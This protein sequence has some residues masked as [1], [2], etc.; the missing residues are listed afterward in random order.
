[1]QK[2]N[3]CLKYFCLVFPFLVFKAVK[4]TKWLESRSYCTKFLCQNVT[5][6]WKSKRKML[7]HQALADPS[8][9]MCSVIGI[10]TLLNSRLLKSCVDVQCLWGAIR[11]NSV[12]SD[13]ETV[14][15]WRS[16]PVWSTL[17]HVRSIERIWDS[18]YTP[19]QPPTRS[20]K[21]ALM[22]SGTAFLLVTK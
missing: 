6:I 11:W 1:M 17:T 10:Q 16:A 8:A 18:T 14:C 9:N 19:N 7:K 21:T 15:V 13:G 4:R 3:T 22:K 5:N 20:V 12:Q 2:R